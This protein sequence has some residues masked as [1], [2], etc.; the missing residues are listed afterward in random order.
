MQY[1]DVQW[2][3]DHAGEPV[4]LVS[5][6]DSRRYEVRKLEFFRTG[7]VGWAS[8]ARNQLGTRLGTAPV[9]QLAEINSD[10]RFNAVALA[11]HAF[12]Q[13]WKQYVCNGS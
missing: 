1:I 11:P 13:L 12:E 8:A 10:P 5:E 4:R 6:I 7:K 9:P 3:H 2:F